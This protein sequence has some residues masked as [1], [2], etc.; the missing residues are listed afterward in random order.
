MSENALLRIRVQPNSQKNEVV[1]ILS[2]G[3][4]KIKLQAPP[5]DGKANKALIR[6]LH[7]LFNIPE[8]RMNLLQGEHNRDKVIRIEGISDSEA[9]RILLDQVSD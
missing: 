5:L 4:I 3:R 7:Q 8:T 6:Y 1:G 9:E 2:D